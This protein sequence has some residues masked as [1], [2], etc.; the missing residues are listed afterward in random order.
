MCFL[1]PVSSSDQSCV[2][3]LKNGEH[4]PET[5]TQKASDDQVLG[6]KVEKNLTSTPEKVRAMLTTPKLVQL[7]VENVDSFDMEEVQITVLS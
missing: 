3:P 4:P 6:V 2:G 1:S 5:D 7:R